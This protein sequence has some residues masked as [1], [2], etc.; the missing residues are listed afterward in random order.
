MDLYSKGF[1]PQT[2]ADEYAIKMAW[3]QRHELNLDKETNCISTKERG[4]IANV[5]MAALCATP[6]RNVL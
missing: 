1:E 4:F 5:M 6:L 3:L 2:Q